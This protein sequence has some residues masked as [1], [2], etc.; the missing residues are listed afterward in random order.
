[1]LATKISQ[2]K[3]VNNIKIIKSSLLVSVAGGTPRQH[4]CNVRHLQLSF[5]ML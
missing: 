4:P 3:R 5:L 2:N 1:M